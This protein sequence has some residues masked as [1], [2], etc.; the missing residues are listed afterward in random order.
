[1]LEV[2]KTSS[3]ITFM[4]RAFARPVPAF[5]RAFADGICGGPV[6]VCYFD[7]CRYG[8]CVGGATATGSFGSRVQFRV[9]H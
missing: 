3:P 2:T 7:P 6:R 1:M 4:P 8:S 9:L 5:F